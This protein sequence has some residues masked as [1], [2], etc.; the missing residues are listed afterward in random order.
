[1]PATAWRAS[2]LSVVRKETGMLMKA[3]GSGPTAE[4]LGT[5]RAML[6]HWNAE[7]DHY[8]RLAQAA[9]SGGEV[10]PGSVAEGEALI[11]QIRAGLE[12]TDMLMTL[13]TAGDPALSTLL[14]AGAE[15]E[16]LLESLE[17]SVE[18][19]SAARPAGRQVHVIAHPGPAAAQA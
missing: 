3:D 8:R 5:W 16:A 12:R 17:T 1:M 7:A 4:A 9:R 15:F 18:L 13:T 19:L 10:L 11:A 14:L 2:A 6:P